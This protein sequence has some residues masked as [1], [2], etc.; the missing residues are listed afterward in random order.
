[1]FTLIDHEDKQ[2][3]TDILTV[4]LVYLKKNKIGLKGGWSP[5]DLVLKVM[6]RPLL[7]SSLYGQKTAETCMVFAALG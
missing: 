2:G 1:M 6:V 3:K 4:K 5:P 7:V